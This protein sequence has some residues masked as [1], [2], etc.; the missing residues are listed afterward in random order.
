MKYIKKYSY[1]EWL[2]IIAALTLFQPNYYVTYAMISVLS[3]FVLFR[4]KSREKIYAFKLYNYFIALFPIFTLPAA[5]SQ[6]WLGLMQGLCFWY[7]LT[8]VCCMF[9][10]MTSEFY[11]KIIDLMLVLSIFSVIYAFVEM[12][13]LGMDRASATFTHPNYYASAIEV[14]IFTAFYRY[15]KTKKKIYWLVILANVCGLVM[16]NCRTAWLALAAAVVFYVIYYLRNVRVFLGITALVACAFAV[17]FIFMPRMDSGD[18]S[19]STDVRLKIWQYAWVKISQNPMIGYGSMSFMDMA[20]EISYDF[21]PHAHNIIFNTLLDFGVVGF[22]AFI[23]MFGKYY[24][25]L[26]R[27]SKYG[28]EYDRIMKLIMTLSVC[29]LAHGMLDAIL[30]MAH[31]YILTFIILS[32]AFVERNE[33]L[34]RKLPLRQIA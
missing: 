18:L 8:F 16:T 11:N 10:T 24:R 28:A 5:M 15:T 34:N 33:R 13:F 31:M 14:F 32:G 7:G 26:I 1:D 2:I 17:I 6:N 30:T 29:F 23:T 4:K 19:D 21:T 27:N 22:V 20:D 9:C 25:V 3:S 12:R